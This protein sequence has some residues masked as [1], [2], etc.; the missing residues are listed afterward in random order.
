MSVTKRIYMD[1]SP[2]AHGQF[3]LAALMDG[4]QLKQWLEA[5]CLKAIKGKKLPTPKA[6]S[7]KRP[8]TK[9][10]TKRR[11]VKKARKKASKTRVAK[12]RPAEKKATKKAAKKTHKR[13]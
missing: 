9:R 4:M 8:T 13:S 10:T 6:A 12:K 5:T 7:K 1:I 11:P 3:K 2:E